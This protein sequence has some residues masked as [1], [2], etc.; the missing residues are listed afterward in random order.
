MKYRSVDDV[1]NS[2]M[3]LFKEQEEDREILKRVNSGEALP[4]DQRFDSRMEMLL[5]EAEDSGEAT[6][7]T[8]EDWVEIRREGMALLKTRKSA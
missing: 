3:Q 4:V 1:I 6:E 8:A 5:Q 2:A 7:M